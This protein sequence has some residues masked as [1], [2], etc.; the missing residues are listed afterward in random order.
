MNKVNRELIVKNSYVG[1]ND[2]RIKKGKARKIKV[3]Q[4]ID[5]KRKRLVDMTTLLNF[6]IV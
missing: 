5:Y 3:W 4:L 2:L 1:L 6:Q